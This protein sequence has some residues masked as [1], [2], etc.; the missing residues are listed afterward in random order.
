MAVEQFE[1]GV[2][3][4]DYRGILALLEEAER[5]RTVTDFRRAVLEALDEHLGYRLGTFFI[6]GPP[7]RDFRPTDGSTHGLREVD[8]EEY[9]E[10]WNA[11]DP[12]V[13]SAATRAMRNRGLVGLSELVPGI[14]PDQRRYLEDFLL[15]QGKS[16]LSVW[17]D[18]GT[19]G[20]GYLSIFGRS[21]HELGERDRAVL[22]TLRPHLT[23]LLR[24]LL[25]DG[26][27][28]PGAERLSAREI[29]V[30]RLVSGGWTN[31]EI[32]RHLGIGEDTV[33]KHLWRA[34]SKLGLHNRT[35]LA[36]IFRSRP[37]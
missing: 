21:S 18:T 26:R 30:A 31:R 2:R 17:L 10:R 15:R 29:E 25:L 13:S 11:A 28:V 37:G 1:T 4:D 20:H 36:L 32:G 14:L 34:M 7:D 12:F 23:Y 19:P 35:Q 27:P 24:A 33:K 22:R 16:Q 3:P 8:M 6:A 5:A 9:V